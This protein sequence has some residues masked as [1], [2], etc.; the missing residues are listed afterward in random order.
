MIKRSNSVLI[1]GVTNQMNRAIFL[2]FSIA[3]LISFS[4]T[5]SAQNSCANPVTAT[6]A[7]ADLNGD[8]CLD[9]A[10]DELMQDAMETGNP[11]GDLNGSG[12]VN[13]S[14]WALYQQAKQ[15]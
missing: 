12:T 4:T 13:V 9:D 2:L 10:D 5:V 8:G 14:D 11:V 6:N 7:A 15:S 1:W 3:A